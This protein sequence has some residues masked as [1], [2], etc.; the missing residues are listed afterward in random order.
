VGWSALFWV[1]MYYIVSRIYTLVRF[2]VSNAAQYMNDTRVAEG[3][4]QAFPY[5]A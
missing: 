1:G 3:I 5:P 4:L 2:G